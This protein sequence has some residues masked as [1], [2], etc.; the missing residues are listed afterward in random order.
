MY[1]SQI[2]SFRFIAV[3]L[4]LVSH[5]MHDVA[6]VNALY[7]GPMGVEFFFAISGFLIS[8]QLYDYY[9]KV[10][11]NSVRRSH[12]LKT[13]FARRVLRIFPLYYFVLFLLT[14]F[15]VGTLRQAFWWNV[16]YLSNFYFIKTEQWAPTF[17]HFWSLSVEEH[18][19]LVWPLLLLFIPRRW[20]P[21]LF[22]TLIIVAVGF[23]YYYFYTTPGYF[24]YTYCHTIACL[25]LFMM[26]AI[27]AYLY[28]Y[29]RQR[30]D[31]FFGP[32][33]LRYIMPI[34]FV[35]LV[36]YWILHPDPEAFNAIYRRS[37]LSVFYAYLIGTLVVGVRGV[38]GWVYNNSM[39]ISLGKLSY[40][41][42]LIHNFIPVLLIDLRDY[43][44]RLW[45]L[46]IIYFIV[47]IILSYLLHRFVEQ[48][49]RRWNRYFTLE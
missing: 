12:A 21:G 6:Y 5:W 23:R 1:F 27:L 37:F 16:S 24:F 13:F 18:F 10:R 14:A 36:V 29:Q 28:K 33:W 3:F 39:L 42:Y 48:P 2:D 34:L 45:M 8:L 38:F 20:W 30:F 32:G 40:G 46:F 19:Y 22:V 7:L 35:A 43:G 44:L 41:I 4:V 31:Y 49:M 17:S 15:D 11:T 25:G 9:E 26:G 47:T